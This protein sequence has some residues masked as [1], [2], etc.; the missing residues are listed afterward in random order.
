MTKILWLV[1]WV[2][3]EGLWCLMPLSTIFQLYHG[4][5]FYWWRELECQEKTTD[6]SQDTGKLYQIM[7]YRVDL[8]QVGFELT[9]VVIGTDC[10][11]SCKSNYHTIMTAPGA[12][13]QGTNFSP[14][15]WYKQ[16]TFPR[17]DFSF[18][19]D[20]HA[21]GCIFIVPAHWNNSVCLDMSLHSGHITLN[22]SQPILALTPYYCVPSR[23]AVNTN[24]SLWFDFTRLQHNIIHTRDKHAMYYTKRFISLV[25]SI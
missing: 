11:G 14:K 24:S 3:G 1:E 2:I 20:H 12:W 17:D 8:T 4:G 7:L 16:V 6:L 9:S 21:F 22:L 13:C 18:V 5:Q 25:Y 19:L 10:I 15:S 23:E